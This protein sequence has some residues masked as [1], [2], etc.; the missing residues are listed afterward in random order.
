R[1][2]A[3]RLAVGRARHGDRDRAT[4]AV[5]GESH[6]TY[7]VAEVLAAELGAD[8]GRL[9]ELEHPPL[10]LDVAEAVAGR[11]PRGGQAIEVAGRCELGGLERELGG[12]AADRDR[13]VVRR[14]GGG[15]EGLDLLED[16]R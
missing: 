7:V 5:A 2:P 14:A 16:P 12:R 8:A 9:G 3:Q 11:R 6:H 13:Q 10:E 1:D 4:G 15:A